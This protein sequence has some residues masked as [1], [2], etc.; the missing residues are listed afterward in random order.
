MTFLDNTGLAYF[1][2]KLKEK[3]IRSVNSITPDDNGNV[4]ITNVATADNLTSPDAQASYDQFVYRT[5]GGS[6]SL[7]SGEAQLV[8]I[9]GNIDI[10]DRVQENFDI[11][12]TNNIN[13]S[14]N[15]SSWRDQIST[16]GTYVFSYTRPTSETATNSWTPNL[17]NWS[18]NGQSP[19]YLDTYGLTASNIYAPSLNL[20]VTG[21]NLSAAQ[22]VPNTWMGQ[23]LFSGTYSFIY[24]TSNTSWTY[25]EENITLSDYGITVNGTPQNGDNI[26]VNYDTG[27]PDSTITVIYTAPQ[28]GTIVVAT[29]TI[30]SATGFNQFD[31]N[32][33]YVANATIDNGVIASD[34]GTYLCYCRAK[35]GVTNGY[36]A[37][38]ESG[39]IIGIGWCENL[40]TIGEDVV[41]ADA[42][43]TST[44]A[45]IP[46]D[47]DGYVVVAV[48]SMND[49]CIHPK[50]SGRADNDYADYVAPSTI[51]LPTEDIEGTD[52]PIG[53]YG[54]PAVKSVA[55]RL[56]LEAGTYI[57][58]IGRLT[59]TVENMNYVIGLE[60]DYDYDS[61]YIY[62]VLK[63]PVTYTVD[64]DP[65]YIVNDWGTEEF[66]GTTVA[67]GAQTL[68]GQNLR[69]KLRTDVLTIS[70]QNPILDKTQKAQ[71]LSNIGAV[72]TSDV[73]YKIYNS[74]V[75]L[76][77]TS[78]S[79]TISDAWTALRAI[80]PAMLVCPSSEFASAQRPN[81]YGTITIAVAYSQSSIVRGWV[82]FHGYGSGVGDYRQFISSSDAKPI[83]TWVKV[84]DSNSF[85]IENVTVLSSVSINSG[86]YKSAS[87]SITKTGYTP[88]SIC[89]VNVSGTT[90]VSNCV[91]GSFY[92]ADNKT[93]VYCRI[94]N[95][96][97]SQSTV[98][99]TASILYVKS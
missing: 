97:S 65:I 85:T 8:Y 12:T 38:S 91:V 52:I 67:L 26:K 51:T 73:K 17:G 78:E 2:G 77:L 5:S 40:P 23:I 95:T 45:S 37:Y 54:M 28:Q 11:T 99:C 96:G 61:S 62:Y 83:G 21:T 10:V 31:K 80:A 32:S 93:K 71:V 27:T 87:V 19:I 89:G 53:I 57:Q 24:N 60:V 63:T 58:K 3:F 13:T 33:M 70:E 25:E 94:R 66:V 42:S 22:I 35:G 76:G 59:N 69:D 68:Y 64:I 29:P 39:Q 43:I 90:N 36:V 86:S 48:T 7:S 75:D 44:L 82:D 16:S 4:A 50:W 20:S 9:D 1:Y 81:Q 56:N 14:Y 72:G 15:A 34:I 46:F 74:V 84:T 98:T 79:A 47:E 41:T 6:A 30:F 92:F 49:L 88:I 18:Y 55:D